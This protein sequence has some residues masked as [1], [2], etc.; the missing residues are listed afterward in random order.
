MPGKRQLKRGSSA[1][2]KKKTKVV[3]VENDDDSA[4]SDDELEAGVYKVSS[5]NDD[6]SG[7]VEEDGMEASALSA[8][9]KRL[10]L[11]QEYM[12]KLGLS[13]GAAE[14]EEA[15]KSLGQG[16]GGKQVVKTLADQ[17]TLGTPIVYKSARHMA[18]CVEMSPSDEWAYTGG[19]DARIYECKQ[20]CVNELSY[21]RAHSH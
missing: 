15:V 18:T 2:S 20:L 9:E 1:E 4:S 14:L 6:N 19:K 5:Q 16:N 10:M 17:I 12:E 8:E 21:A 3:A 7:E 11:A 13:Y